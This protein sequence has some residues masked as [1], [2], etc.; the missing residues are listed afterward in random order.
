MD[1]NLVGKIWKKSIA[2]GILLEIVF[3]WILVKMFGNHYEGEGIW[4]DVFLLILAFW[5]VQIFFGLKDLLFWYINFKINR[6]D[7][8]R[9]EVDFLKENE[10]PSPD[11]SWDLDNPDLYYQDVMNNEQLPVNTRIH[12]SQK[13]TAMLRNE[14]FGNMIRAVVLNNIYK[15]SLSKYKIYCDGEK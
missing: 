3:A 6:D 13:Y 7:F 8:L 4:G 14:G 10:F 9:A 1:N 2:I 11:A 15:E 5:S 12:A